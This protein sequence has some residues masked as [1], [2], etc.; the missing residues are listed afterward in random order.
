MKS[1]KEFIN[2]DLN[3]AK[4]TV[5]KILDIFKNDEDWPEFDIK[6]YAKGKNLVIINGFFYGGDRQ[7]ETLKKSWSPG[8]EYYEYFLKEYGIKFKIVNTFSEFK[9]KGRHKKLTT[10]GIVGVELEIG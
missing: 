4:M 5:R 2:E 1:F 10:D 6:A 8:G 3:E 7:M 9:A